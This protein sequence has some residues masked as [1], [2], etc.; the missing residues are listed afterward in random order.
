MDVL[1]RAGET[2][3]VGRTPAHPKS[4]IISVHRIPLSRAADPEFRQGVPT[5]CPRLVS[6]G[7]RGNVASLLMISICAV[8]TAE[9]NKYSNMSQLLVLNSLQV[10]YVMVPFA[11]SLGSLS[12]SGAPG[13]STAASEQLN[14]TTWQVTLLTSP[15]KLSPC[16]LCLTVVCHA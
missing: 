13:L 12:S 1:Y 7:P 16:L 8:C 2:L 5:Y 6:V 9:F 14:I 10:H 11:G 3:Q 4:R 15:E